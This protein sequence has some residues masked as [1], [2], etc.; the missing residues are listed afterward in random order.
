MPS[1]RDPLAAPSH[2]RIRYRLRQIRELMA[3]WDAWQR[4]NQPADFQPP[5][6]EEADVFSNRLPWAASGPENAHHLRFRI[7]C[8]AQELQRCEEELRFLP[9]DA[10]NALRYLE[11]QLQLLA[12]GVAAAQVAGQLA[13]TAAQ[14]A[15]WCGKA[16]VLRAW[17]ARIATLHQDSLKLCCEVGWMEVLPAA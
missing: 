12:T 15:M 11:H 10:Q 7:Y 9:M 17:Q 4:F 16:H 6:W 14:Q 8:V 3:V 2:C 5:A 1:H 13:G